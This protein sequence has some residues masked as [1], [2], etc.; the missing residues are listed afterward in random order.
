MHPQP[1][2]RESIF[3]TTDARSQTAGEDSPA[4]CG[5]RTTAHCCAPRGDRPTPNVDG[6][7]T[8]RA[9][10]AADLQSVRSL[11][12]VAGLPADD[13]DRH[14]DA[15]YSLAVSDDGTVIGSA[16]VEVYGG[17]GLL[18]SVAVASPWRGRGVGAALV[19]DRLAWAREQKL[20]ALWLLT[21]T[22]ADYFSTLG[23]RRTDRT[24]APH[25]LLTASEFTHICP[26]TATVMW[27]DLGPIGAEAGCGVRSCGSDPNPGPSVDRGR[28]TV[29][30][31]R[32]DCR[33]S[34]SAGE[35]G[36]AALAALPVVVIGAGPVGLAAAAHL[37]AKGEPL[38]VIE[39]GSR[40]GASVREW[41][42]VR[43]FSPWKYAVDSTAR[44]MLESAGW[45]MPDAETLPTGAQLVES[46]LEP[47]AE[48]PEIAP[49]LR[50]GYHVRAVSRRGYDKLK[51]IGRDSAPFELV[52][53]QP[54]G[55]IARVYARAVIDA[56]G[57]WR[58]PAPMGASGVAA[59]GEADAA[60][61]VAYGMP[62]VL[63]RDRVRYE[64]KR[65]LVV[66]SGHSAF[67]V[68]LDLA[69]LGRD[70]GTQVSWAIRRNEPGL[71]F[72]GG[73]RDGLPERGALGTR[74]R[75]LVDDGRVRLHTGIRIARVA[76]VDGALFVTGDDGQ[77]LGPT[78]EI[79]VTTGFRPDLALARELRLR[80]DPSLEAPEG[81]APLIDPNQHSCGTVY[82]HGAAELAHPE[83]GY[84]VVG[85]KSYGRAPTFL[86]LTG[87]E[88]VRSV[89]CELVGDHDGARQ[90]KLVLPETG[91]CRVD[92]AAAETG[93]TGGVGC[94]A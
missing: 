31:A 73:A 72:G 55:S 84:Y 27:M 53:Q 13:I 75:R 20:D 67:N 63:G 59:E 57:T 51:T 71:M 49:H 17:V 33:E 91:V 24:D 87:Y 34:S 62:D 22:A 58:T 39:A 81:L 77:R 68:L 45:T 36:P 40:V 47:L 60:E 66:G 3:M 42:H 12:V 35:P 14:F 52:I 50:F 90:V 80:L 23:F 83:G 28:C 44:R 93:I 37:V 85:M 65:V 82:P 79:I 86:L 38:L 8:V 11:L 78:D 32:C 30:A 26:S 5:T 6:V 18:R 56:S 43:L 74:L 61:H 89:V 21:T 94:C 69:R 4:C 16:G 70:A 1:S 25:D 15:G 76:T 46:Y 92:Q 54:N 9:A 48:L 41:G 2:E 7:F 29:P 10:G 64:G 88:Q 19:Q